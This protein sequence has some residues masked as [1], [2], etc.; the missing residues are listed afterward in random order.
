MAR[1]ETWQVTDSPVWETRSPYL[2][3]TVLAQKKEIETQS[4]QER[5]RLRHEADKQRKR[6]LQL[7]Q[8]YKQLQV[9]SV[10]QLAF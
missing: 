10:G 3:K 4:T 1:S 8:H 9:D 7:E 2:V 5:G 6:A